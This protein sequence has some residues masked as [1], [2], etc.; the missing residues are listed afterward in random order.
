[1]QMTEKQ[2]LLLLD[3]VFIA[4]VNADDDKHARRLSKLYAKMANEYEY[5]Q[6]WVNG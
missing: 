1:M 4:E 6:D 3:A 5:S 2:F